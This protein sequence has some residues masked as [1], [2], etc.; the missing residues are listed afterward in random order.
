MITLSIIIP[1]F[2]SASTVISNLEKIINSSVD[3]VED[4]YIIDDNSSIESYTEIRDFICSGKLGNITTLCRLRRNCGA[5]FCR[6]L[7]LRKA[8]GD[9]IVFLDADDSISETYLE[10][11]HTSIVRN[12]LPEFLFA[13]VIYM[14]D[15][16]R[17]LSIAPLLAEGPARKKYGSK[18]LFRYNFMGVGIQTSAWIVKRSL[19]KGSFW[20]LGLKGHQD[21]FFLMAFFEYN[22]MSRPIYDSEIVVFRNKFS[23]GEHI[24]DRLGFNFSLNFL[25]ENLQMFSALSKFCYIISVVSIKGIKKSHGVAKVFWLSAFFV[26]VFRFSFCRYIIKRFFK[27]AV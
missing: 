12:K 17:V 23:D 11:V 16:K 24:S 27:S 20:K 3:I 2:N 26:N 25:K 19:V 5:N 14:K 4:I 21:W 13:N 1:H 8:K 6:R 22:E 9:Y 7:G 18:L 10:S 15:L